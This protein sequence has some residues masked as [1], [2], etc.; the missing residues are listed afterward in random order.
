VTCADFRNTTIARHRFSYYTYSM[1]TTD[2]AAGLGRLARRKG[3]PLHLAVSDA[4][5][6]Y[7]G[8]SAADVRRGWYAERADQHADDD[9]GHLI[10]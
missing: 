3:R 6:G 5:A 10:R 7:P 8:L 1:N 2:H 4:L 9:S